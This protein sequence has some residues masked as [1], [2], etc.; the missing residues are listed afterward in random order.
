MIILCF[1]F[2]FLNLIKPYEDFSFYLILFVI[3]M[4]KIYTN[5]HNNNNKSIVDLAKHYK[6]YFI[7]S[8]R[9]KKIINIRYNKFPFVF[10]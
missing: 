3:S 1:S 5:N 9:K 6:H 10:S 8:F 7:F 4:I 2:F